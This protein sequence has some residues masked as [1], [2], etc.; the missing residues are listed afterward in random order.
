MPI[1]AHLPVLLRNTAAFHLQ[2]TGRISDRAV[3]GCHEGQAYYKKAPRQR[4]TAWDG[5]GLPQKTARAYG[6]DLPDKHK[7]AALLAIGR[8]Y[9]C[10]PGLSL[11]TEKSVSKTIPIN[12]PETISETPHLFLESFHVPFH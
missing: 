3:R 2:N 11:L 7:K 8:F 12:N 1:Q 10:L 5:S 4:A 9:L 6:A